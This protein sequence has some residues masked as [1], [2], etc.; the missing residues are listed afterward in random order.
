MKKLLPILLIPFCCLG[1]SKMLWGKWNNNVSQASGGY[2]AN[3]VSYN[4]S[5]QGLSKTSITGLADGKQGLLSFWI[6]INGGDGTVFDLIQTAT[7]HFR[8]TRNGANHFEIT[9]STS[10]GTTTL[11]IETSVTWT[12][13][14]T[15]HHVIASWD[16]TGSG[17]R[18]LYVDDAENVNVFTFANNAI[19]YTDGTWLMPN[20]D[21]NACI[22]EFYFTTT[23][24]DVSIASNRRLF[25]TGGSPLHPISL[26]SNGSTPTGSQ[27]IVYMKDPAATAGNNSGSGGT[28]TINGG[29][30]SACG[31]TP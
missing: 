27:P 5:S 21:A 3:T 10:A 1:D 29:P 18:H 12:T 25:D 31:S 11:D 15:W 14:A 28:F 7:P 23:W 20:T 8:L 30:L 22:A 17:T 13:S 4:G 9:G 6:K 19:N 2:T 26:G 16:L 24:L